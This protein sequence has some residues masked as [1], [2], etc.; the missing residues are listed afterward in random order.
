MTLYLSPDV[1][2]EQTSGLENRNV[3]RLC[4]RF[5]M[6]TTTRIMTK[7]SVCWYVIN[8]THGVTQQCEGYVE[9]GVCS[10]VHRPTQT[11]YAGKS[12]CPECMKKRNSG[13]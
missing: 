4:Q 1:S 6:C 2:F 11:Q 8:T 12:S 13:K 9:D 10:G 5:K 3:T 7:C